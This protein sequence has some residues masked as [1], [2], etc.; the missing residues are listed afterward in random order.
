MRER[1]GY[2]ERVGGEAARG[3]EMTES[4]LLPQETYLV[5]KVNI[6][7]LQK[8]AD[9]KPFLSDDSDGTGLHLIDL[10]QTDA[11]MRI[12]SQFLDRFDPSRILVVSARQYGQRPARLFAEAIG[13]NAAV[14]RFIPGSLTNPALSSYVEPDVL[15]VTDPAADQQALIEAVNTGLPIIGLVDANNNLR[16]VDIAIPA[17]NKGRRSLALVYWLLAREVL[18]IRGETTDES[19]A[20]TQDIEEWQSSF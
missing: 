5:H 20:E 9:M 13:A 3:F 4:M 18:K 11:R 7:A 12:V 19:W 15:F 17:N 1:S 6:G 8:S 16:N 14:G 2:E 10:E